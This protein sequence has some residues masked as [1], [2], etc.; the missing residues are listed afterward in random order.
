MLAAS[1]S[2]VL[3]FYLASKTLEQAIQSVLA[4][5]YKHFELILVANNADEESLQIAKKYSSLSN[6]KLHFEAQQG[7]VFAMNTACRL[8]KCKWIARM[9]ADDIWHPDKLKAQMDF[10]MDHPNI[11]VVGCQWNLGASNSTEG[12]LAYQAWQNAIL[13]PSQIQQNIFVELPIANPSLLFK[14]D[15]LQRFGFYKK[16]DFPEDYEMLLR[17][18]NESVQMA[19]IKAEYLNWNNYPNRL[20]TSDAAYSKNAFN[21]IRCKYLARYLEQ[22]NIDEIWVWGAGRKSRRFADELSQYGIKIVGYIDIVANKTSL[23]PCIHYSQINKQ[24]QAF[25]VSFVSNRNKRQEVLKYL[26]SISYV[27]LKSFVIAA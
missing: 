11:E 2:V 8:A 27:N 13:T 26:E 24:K 5:S 21:Y 16:G 20:T 15:L 3:P 14:A 19:K 10:L 7:V 23:L 17:W 18:N 12:L 1:I 22:L 6:V 9:D 4:Q 25:I